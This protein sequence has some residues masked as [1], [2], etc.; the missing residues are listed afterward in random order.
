MMLA[1]ALADY[2]PE[3]SLRYAGWRVVLAC[4]VMAIFAWGFGFYGQAVYLAELGRLYAWPTSLIAGASTFFYLLGAGLVVFVGD[5]IKRWAPRRVVLGAALILALALAVIATTQRPY[6]LYLGYGVMAF[7]WAGMSLATIN[8]IIGLWFE[9]RRGLAISLA[10]NGAS[11]GGVIVAPLLVAASARWGFRATMLGA[12]AAVPLLLVPILAALVPPAPPRRHHQHAPLGEGGAWTRARALRDFGFWTIAAPFAL[13]LTAQVGFLVH[14]VA[15]LAPTIGRETAGLAVAIASMAAVVGRV[16]F[17]FFID[18]LDQR[19]VSALA[20]LSQAVALLAM[21]QTTDTGL[22]L[23]CAALFGLSVGNVITLPALILQREFDPRAF[24]LLIG[25]STG[26]GQVTYALGPG[27][28][29][30]LRDLTG[31]YAAPL[32]LCMALEV[33][34]AIIVLWRKRRAP[35]GAAAP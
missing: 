25:L 23:V 35:K 9:E 6:Q 32:A 31:S 27:L 1:P 30:A 34:A 11:F 16:S 26:I 20:F 24:A 19:L 33:V 2:P 29:G 4:F 21:T 28:L 13:A 15:F 10:L 3:R 22:L 17:G 18:R 12:A 8:T 7:A 14:Q 5:G